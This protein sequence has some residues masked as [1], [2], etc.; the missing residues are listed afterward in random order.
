[1]EHLL[2]RRIARRKRLHLLLKDGA[3]AAVERGGNLLDGKQNRPE[4]EHQQTRDPA[5]A[6][7]GIHRQQA[8]GLPAVEKDGEE[9][10]R[11]PVEK[12]HEA[13]QRGADRH[14]QR[15]AHGDG[16]VKVERT[17][18]RSHRRRCLRR[19]F[20]LGHGLGLDDVALRLSALMAEKRVGR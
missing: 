2:D 5:Q 15:D 4:A 10:G 8:A 14:H 3:D 7:A 11:H 16:I 17:L 19:K 6:H 20:H 13:E 9:T 12:R 1:M 18:D